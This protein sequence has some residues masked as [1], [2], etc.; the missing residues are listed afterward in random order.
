MKLLRK[1]PGLGRSAELAI[2]DEPVLVARL[3][4]FVDGGRLAGTLA[5]R[6]Q[7]ELMADSL[8]DF[9]EKRRRQAGRN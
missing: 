6:L 2:S 3:C 1:I 7:E 8:A 9:G 5:N 4:H